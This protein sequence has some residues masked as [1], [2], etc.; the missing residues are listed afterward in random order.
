MH[1][2]HVCHV[3]VKAGCASIGIGSLQVLIMTY[4]VRV[5]NF[6]AN[7]RSQQSMPQCTD[8]HVT[9]AQGIAPHQLI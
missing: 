2:Q 1:F 3:N 7:N 8:A 5:Q 6:K 9:H 4:A